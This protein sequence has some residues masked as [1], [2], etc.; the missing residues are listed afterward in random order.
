MLSTRFPPFVK[1]GIRS[2]EKRRPPLRPVREKN[3]LSLFT[4]NKT[5][6]SNSKS[7]TELTIT[8]GQYK[9]WRDFIY[10][11]SGINLG[12]EK[13]DLVRARLS[14]RMREL[15]IVSF[16]DYYDMVV[17]RDQT[18][19]EVTTAIDLLTTNKTDFFREREHFDMIANQIIPEW[20]ADSGRSG[21]RKLRIWC[22]ACSSGEE[23]YTIAMTL[24]GIPSFMDEW[25][26]KI[27]ASDLSTRI[28]RTASTG[29][30]HKDRFS[31]VDK[32]LLSRY[33]SKVNDDRYQ[34][35]DQVKRHI[36]F[37]HHN[38]ITGK[39][40][41]EGKLDIVFCR[42]VM[43]YFD[44]PTKATLVANLARMLK[45]GG[46]LFVGMSESLQRITAG[47]KY[48]APSVYKKDMGGSAG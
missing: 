2:S 13:H 34:V 41:F 45:P 33:F 30:Y 26:V 31:G 7:S 27:L 15:S 23:P 3:T 6:Q 44:E 17:N 21:G 12:P 14:K 25:N 46:Y 29:V 19:Q 24:L 1:F 40:P 8:P 9:K 36:V 18:G 22:A 38:L 11:K 43:I 39:F 16:D 47:L 35:I 37:R 28:L 42:N 20:R 32:S 48:V 5:G 10:E 4:K